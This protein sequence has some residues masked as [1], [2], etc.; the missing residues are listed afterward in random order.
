MSR[1]ALLIA[2]LFALAAPAMLH[3]QTGQVTGRIV[4][5]ETEQPLVDAQVFV[6]GTNRSAISNQEGRFTIT[7]VPA[8]RQQ[9]RVALVGYSQGEETV[10]V[11]AAGTATANFR[12]RTSPVELAA[13][14]V[15]AS[16]REQRQR[17]LGV[18]VGTINVQDVE[19]AAINNLSQ[20]LQGRVAG[21]TV[22]QTSGT[23][24]TSSRIRI[25]GANSISL[26]NAP[27]VIVDGVRV[28]NSEAS[29][30]YGV[31]GATPGRLDDISSDDIESIEILKGPAASSM[32][33]TAAANGV[34][35][36]TTRRGRSGAPEFRFWSEL[37]RTQQRTVFEDNVYAEGTLVGGANVAPA[38]VTGPCTVAR[39]AIG[40][41]PAPGEIGCTGI[42]QIHRF[43]PLM[44]PETTPFRNGTRQTVGGS[45]SGGTDGATFYV[46]AQ[47]EDEDGVQAR[48]TLVRNRLQANLSGMLGENF[49][50]G[51]NVGYLDS[52][53]QL[54]QGDNALFGLVPMGMSGDPRPANVEA[55]QGYLADPQFA[56]DWL[57]F[58][59]INR[60]TGSVRANYRPLA[61][62][63]FNGVAGMDRVDRDEVNRLPR[64]NAYS[65]F[66]S[67]YTHGFIQRSDMDQLIYTAT[68]STTATRS[69]NPD[70]V[71]TTSL[72]TQYLRERFR[73]IYTF[74]ASLTPGIET[75]LAG[76]TADF[77]ANEQNAQNATIAA[78]AEQQFAWRDRVYANAALRGDRNSAF[79]TTVSWIWYPSLSASWVVSDEAFFPAA[80]WLSNLRLRAA[81]GQSGL[82]PGATA[83]LQSFA[84]AVTTFAGRDQPAII[85]N[86]VGN[87]ELRP[88]RTTEYEVGF[89]AGL[90]DNRVGFE[91]TYFNRRSQDALVNRPLPPSLGAS[92]ARF[93]NLGQ[94]RNSGL[95]L[96]LSAQAF[97][98][99]NIAF[100]ASL[101]GALFRNELVELGVDAQGEPLPDIIFNRAAQRHREGY[102]LGS[103]FQ[104]RIIGWE[105]S[106]G[107]G[108]LRPDDVQMDTIESYLGNPFPRR[109]V[110]LN[111]GVSLWNWAHV[112]GLLDYKGGH[113]LLNYT[114][115]YRCEDQVC[116]D[117]YDV[118][119][120]LER[121]AAIL[122]YVE[123]ESYAGLI[124][125][126][127]F[128][129]LREVALTLS[130]P[131]T[132]AQRFG[133]GGLSLTVAGRNLRTWTRYTGFDPEVNFQGG[134]TFASS[135]D[136]ITGD[137]YTLPVNRFVTFRID[138][139]F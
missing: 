115:A 62:L 84:A 64:D 107:N 60:L 86:Q 65:I 102:A 98:T 11:T 34:I 69:I 46:S 123:H 16:G 81:V 5:A 9:I 25:R 28:D 13:V 87:P 59:D 121:Q 93:E 36:I 56:A 118:N 117:V 32:Y 20:L 124:E 70:L 27:L 21:T 128:V 19:L 116:A 100:S 104:P 80:D 42:T 109:E 44:N 33:G 126:A 38:N 6:V 138:A 24:G 89:E 18:S 76:A 29:L 111:T 41:T 83:A 75:S 135:G 112:S 7:G 43:N 23:T 119:T 14:I 131:R 99:R 130:A 132:M 63:S 53:L 134:T 66:G 105:D 15:T 48:N 106:G 90:V 137:Q 77:G 45:A 52:S 95:E 50:V 85:I 136:F 39:L 110:S 31:G 51:A 101:T 40:A 4:S 91:L 26:S 67:V 30:Y 82:R 61:W 71:S 88:E 68:A 57:T 10:D 73:H 122:A 96:G 139:N 129:K 79:G 8:G 55:N 92:A 113:R 22:Q 133:I 35:Q 37:G 108:L 12:L 58:Q 1:Y 127:D 114:R 3:A 17:E 78:Y 2:L 49:T 47:R 94:V 54:P 120:P 72:G 97:R 125:D 74:G 103:Y